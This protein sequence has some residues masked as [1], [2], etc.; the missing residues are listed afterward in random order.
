M[1][2]TRAKGC[3]TQWLALP[4][5]RQWFSLAIFFLTAVHDDLRKTRAAGTEVDG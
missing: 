2:L 5:L 4:K 1:W 3:L